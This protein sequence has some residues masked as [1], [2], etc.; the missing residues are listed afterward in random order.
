MAVFVKVEEVLKA[1]AE[2]KG[3]IV[4]ALLGDA[5]DVGGLC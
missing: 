4:K 2:M 1:L 5:N 3:V